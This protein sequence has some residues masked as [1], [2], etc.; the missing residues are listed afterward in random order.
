MQPLSMKQAPNALSP[1]WPGGPHGEPN[2]SRRNTPD[3]AWLATDQTTNGY[4]ARTAKI[5]LDVSENQS[6]YDNPLQ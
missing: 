3:P 6:Q 1:C 4:E 5:G 2:E